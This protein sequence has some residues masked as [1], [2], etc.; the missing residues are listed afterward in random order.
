MGRHADSSLLPVRLSSH[1]RYPHRR[2]K[3]DLTCGD[4]VLDCC[5]VSVV[6]CS[7][8]RQEPHRLA[9]PRSQDLLRRDIVFSFLGKVPPV[10]Q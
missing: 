3:R 2:R 1:T 7:S 4:A 8:C 9:N 6:T 5:T 10:S